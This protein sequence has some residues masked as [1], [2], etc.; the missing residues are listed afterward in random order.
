MEDQLSAGRGRMYACTTRGV[1]SSSSARWMA[2]PSRMVT[3]TV[4]MD[5][6]GWM[7][8]SAPMVMYTSQA[9]HTCVVVDWVGCG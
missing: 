7:F 5:G 3:K 2:S 4:G 1:S 6:C 8:G 9:Q